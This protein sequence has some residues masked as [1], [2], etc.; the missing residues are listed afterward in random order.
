M[1]VHAYLWYTQVCLCVC[2]VSPLCFPACGPNKGCL[3]RN[4]RCGQIM[5]EVIT[6]A[7]S[8]VWL[9]ITLSIGRMK[10]HDR[11]GSD[12]KMEKK[13]KSTAKINSLSVWLPVEAEAWGLTGKWSLCGCV[14]TQTSKLV[15]SNF[16]QR[17]SSV[18]M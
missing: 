12:A 18:V 4:E 13:E 3:Q 7:H 5:E 6:P 1:F 2:P 8:S 14:H 17:G 11:S 16:P 15:Q 10:Q 9:R